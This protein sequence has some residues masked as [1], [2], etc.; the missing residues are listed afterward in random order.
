VV[1]GGVDGAAVVLPEVVLVTEENEVVPKFVLEAVV[2]D[3]EELVVVVSIELELDELEVGEVVDELEVDIEVEVLVELEDV[4][5]LEPP[6]GPI[7]TSPMTKF[8]AAPGQNSLMTRVVTGPPGNV[9]SVVT[10]V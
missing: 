3:E 4:V 8:G 7:P 9:A 2:D 1:R 6:P 10:V 5:E